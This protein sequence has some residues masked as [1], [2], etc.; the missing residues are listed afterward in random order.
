MFRYHAEKATLFGLL[1]SMVHPSLHHLMVHEIATKNPHGMWL[2][3][4][5]H[6]DGHQHK[7]VEAA[8]LLLDHLKLAG[9]HVSTDYTHLCTAIEALEFAQ[10]FKLAELSKLGHLRRLVSTDSRP[11][12]QAIFQHCQFSK[13]PFAETVASIIADWDVLPATPRMAYVAPGPPGPPSEAP[14]IKY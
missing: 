9:K 5:H 8:R 13:T 7:H 11:G 14:P 10:D 2:I 3:L 6:F 1:I 4:C 12:V